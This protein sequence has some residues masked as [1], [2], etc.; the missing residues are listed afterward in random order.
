[1]SETRSHHFVQTLPYSHEE[2]FTALITP[3]HIRRWWNAQ[4]VIVIPKIGGIWVATWG[5]D[6]DHPEFI[7]FSRIKDLVVGK[8]LVLGDYQY[9]SPDGGLAFEADFE[10]TFEILSNP[11]RGVDLTVD[12]TG[13][14]SD[15]IAD[16]YYENCQQ[17]WQDTLSSLERFLRMQAL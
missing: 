7:S 9:V 2:V 17:G 10:T 14:P 15:P 11:E 3:S 13:F 1:M 5:N 12:Q 4:Q 6:F 8:R 16:E